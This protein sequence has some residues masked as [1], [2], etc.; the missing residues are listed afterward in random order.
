MKP[1]AQRDVVIGAICSDKRFR[2]D[3][4]A[5]ESPE[6]V[7]RTLG[8]YAHAKQIGDSLAAA[9][10]PAWDLRN[11]PDRDRYFGDCV[12]TDALVDGVLRF[13]RVWPCR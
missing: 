10:T 12:G 9:V 8:D 13:C 2:G 3:L 7:A 6:E 5:C 1:E 4:F 11:H